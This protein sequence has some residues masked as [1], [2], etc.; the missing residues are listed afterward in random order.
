MKSDLDRI[1]RHIL[2]CLQKNGRLSNKELAATVGLA[3]STCID[4]VKKLRL[5][6]H[7]RGIHAEISPEAMGIHLQAMVFVQLD[8]HTAD[9][10]VGFL[11]RIHEIPEV[12]AHYHV[13]GQHDFVIHLV[14]RDTAHLQQLILSLS[15]TD[16]RHIQTALIFDHQ[17][18]HT[19]PDLTDAQ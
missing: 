17:R 16:V 8:R 1:D 18:A 9:H 15:L 5:S 19:F 10:M 6:G 13:A 12:L 4:R 14:A 11:E 2:Q 7:L 3:P